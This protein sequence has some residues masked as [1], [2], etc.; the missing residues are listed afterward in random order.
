MGASPE[1]RSREEA[2]TGIRIARLAFRVERF[3]FRVQEMTPNNT[4]NRLG[5]FFPWKVRAT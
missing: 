3:M 5:H 2:A 1:A 4:G